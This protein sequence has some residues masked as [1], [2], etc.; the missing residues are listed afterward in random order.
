MIELVFCT[1]NNHKLLEV[2]KMLDLGNLVL[3]SLEDIA[4]KLPIHEVSDSFDGNAFLKAATIFKSTGKNVIADDSGLEVDALNGAPG[5]ISARYAGPDATDSQ[6]RAKLLEMLKGEE[7]RSARFRTSIC[8]IIEGQ[9]NFYHGLIEG[10]I[11]T[12]EKGAKGFGYDAI[13]KPMGYDLSFAEM[14]PEE[15]NLISH[16]A[17]AIANLAQ[18]L[19]QR[20]GG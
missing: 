4:W 11:L 1:T 8:S 13:F 3:R 16:R 10:D 17:I 18:A 2:S 19:R 14:N 9:V 15:K 5:V 12:Q 20:F 6:N 7:N